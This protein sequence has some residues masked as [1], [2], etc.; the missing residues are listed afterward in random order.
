[1]PTEGCAATAGVET[2][3]TCTA[4]LTD[5]PGWHKHQRSRAD[6]ETITAHCSAMRMCADSGRNTP[7]FSPC[8]VDGKPQS[9]AHQPCLSE[10]TYIC[11]KFSE[12]FPAE[13]GLFV[14]PAQAF[15]QRCNHY[16]QADRGVHEYLAEFAAFRRRNKFAPGDGLG[17]RR[18][19]KSAP[20]HRLRTHPH[21]IMIP[22]E[23]NILARA[24]HP[25]LAVRPKLL[26]PVPRYT[27]ADGKDPQPLLL[28]QSFR[29]MIQIEEGIK[30]ERRLA[31][32]RAH[33]VVQGHVQPHFG[34]GERRH[35]DRNAL[36]KGRLENAPAFGLL[37][38]IF[39]DFLIQPP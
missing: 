5:L 39:A 11:G 28:Q 13:S 10:S 30:V 6:F 8:P 26:R 18:A 19:G 20:V 12:L 33:A 23:L 31:V 25:Q 2:G 36:F 34:I 24:P 32:S 9:A 27:A 29:E 16:R 15:K 37:F 17:I 4:S 22:L 7:K 35:K 1:M 14:L 21:A 38:E 3:S